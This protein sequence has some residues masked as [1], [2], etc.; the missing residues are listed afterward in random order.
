MNSL[1]L[2]NVLIFFILL[3]SGTLTLNAQGDTIDCPDNHINPVGLGG[4][5]FVYIVV[6]PSHTEPT[7]RM[8]NVKMMNDPAL[9]R[10]CP[11]IY[12]AAYNPANMNL[13]GVEPLTSG[14]PDNTLN[15]P[16]PGNPQSYWF[17]MRF[18]F[19]GYCDGAGGQGTTPI[20]IP[21]L[22]KL[23]GVNA[24]GQY[25][26]YDQVASQGCLDALFPECCFGV[27]Y[28]TNNSGFQG[29]CTFEDIITHEK[30]SNSTSELGQSLSADFVDK[31]DFKQVSLVPNPFTTETQLRL[32]ASMGTEATVQ[33]YDLNGRLL[34]EQKRQLD[35][36]E[37]H[38]TLDT[39]FLQPGA[40][41]LQ[42]RSGE[43][44]HS[45]KMVKQIGLR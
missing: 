6:K 2:G 14:S 13:I 31:A 15:C 8:V 23:V 45:M 22:F 34:S 38:L 40:Y 4:S 25:V 19:T 16:V 3:L 44:V 27:D 10:G 1:K 12:L 28:L 9:L 42:V 21:V 32:R 20:N 33:I 39:E 7:Y 24:L 43:A 29:F 35:A 30:S 37:N 11:S 17:R 5:G 26:L 18:D 36:G 41:F